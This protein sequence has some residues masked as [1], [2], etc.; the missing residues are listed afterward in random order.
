MGS[1]RVYGS[2]K[3][4]EECRVSITHRPLAGGDSVVISQSYQ[5]ETLDT[6]FAQCSVAW[7]FLRVQSVSGCRS[8]QEEGKDT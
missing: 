4:W 8:E 3:V 6:I 2:A 5:F 7:H 1:C